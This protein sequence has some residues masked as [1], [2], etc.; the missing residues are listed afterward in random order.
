MSKKEHDTPR[1]FPEHGYIKR[2]FDYGP[3]ESPYFGTPGG[4][5]KS[6]G[7][8]I[9]KRRKKVRRKAKQYGK[10]AYMCNIYYKLSLGVSI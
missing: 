7:A 8:F 4:G 1:F 10:I 3:S 6:M 9:K 2:N 5:E